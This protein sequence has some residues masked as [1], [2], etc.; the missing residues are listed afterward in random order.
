MARTDWGSGMNI[1][2]HIDRLVIDDLGIQASQRHIL[3]TS[4]A[5]KLAFLL[6]NHGI[7]PELYQDTFVPR[8]SASDIRLMDSNA[9][10]LGQ[11][12]AQSVYGGIGHE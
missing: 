10:N 7:S 1:N 2:L 11:H 5:N 9:T 12:I 8:M 6:Q 3:Q 4:I